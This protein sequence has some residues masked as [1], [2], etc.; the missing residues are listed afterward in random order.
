MD[1]LNTASDS[2][3]ETLR[4]KFLAC[5]FCGNEEAVE[6]YKAPVTMLPWTVRCRACGANGPRADSEADASEAWAERPG[7]D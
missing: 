7:G 5:P 2:T 1:S 4:P 3:K 6:A